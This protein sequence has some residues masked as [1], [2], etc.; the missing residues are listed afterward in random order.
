M[1]GQRRSRHYNHDGAGYTVHTL[2]QFEQPGGT[3]RSPNRIEDDVSVIE[4]CL[5]GS[6][7]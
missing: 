7:V 3:Y 1:D 2:A 6:E 5:S 4:E